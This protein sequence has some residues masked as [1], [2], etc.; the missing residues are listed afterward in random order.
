MGKHFNDLTPAEDERLAY[1]MEECG[2]AIQIIGKIM[3]HGYESYNPHKPELGSNRSLL[4]NELG[5]VLRAIRMLA[6]AGD[7]DRRALD[8]LEMRDPP[9]QYMHHQND[10]E[11]DG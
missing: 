7:L 4:Q 5:D 3:R 6:D 8:Q 2:E 9:Q 1:L 11:W 10:A